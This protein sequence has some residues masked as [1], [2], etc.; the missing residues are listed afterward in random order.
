MSAINRQ[1]LAMQAALEAAVPYAHVSA[2][3][4][5][6]TYRRVARRKILEN[7]LEAG[8]R[9]FAITLR[10][11]RPFGMAGL[12]PR[13]Y[14]AELIVTVAYPLAAHAA[15]A[16]EYFASELDLLRELFEDCRHYA[17]QQ[18]RIVRHEESGIEELGDERLLFHHRFSMLVDEDRPA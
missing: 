5:T 14:E 11:V 7:R 18:V 13:C 15:Q 12:S 3:P 2:Q 9:H 16:E 10:S 4:W 17:D 6:Q 1:I 8:F